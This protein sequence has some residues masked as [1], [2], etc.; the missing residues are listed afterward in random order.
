M[1]GAGLDYRPDSLLRRYGRGPPFRHTRKDPTR[2]DRHLRSSATEISGLSCRCCRL[3]RAAA[4]QTFEIPGDGIRC[5]TERPLWFAIGE[6]DD[7]ASREDIGGEIGNDAAVRDFQTRT[8]VVEWRAI[9]VEFPPVWQTAHGVSP[10]RLDS[11]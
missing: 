3:A 1:T 10:K 11:S 6:H 5:V 7:V 2:P 9:R 4:H 8:V